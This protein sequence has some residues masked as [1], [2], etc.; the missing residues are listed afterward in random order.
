MLMGAACMVLAGSGGP[1]VLLRVPRAAR[2]SFTYAKR[3]GHPS[4]VWGAPNG[5]CAARLRVL[6]TSFAAVGAVCPV[7]RSKGGARSAGDMSVSGYAVPAAG[8]EEFLSNL[9]SC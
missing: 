5:T 9:Q 1:D 3:P 2:S 4:L 7:Q 6:T 8:S